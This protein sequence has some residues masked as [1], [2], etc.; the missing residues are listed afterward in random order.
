MWKKTLIDYLCFLGVHQ[1][2]KWYKS[3]GYTWP[4]E[5]NGEQYLPI[6]LIAEKRAYLQCKWCGA[7]GRGWRD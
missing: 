5:G 3:C 2:E 4:Q 1:W 7:P 6:S